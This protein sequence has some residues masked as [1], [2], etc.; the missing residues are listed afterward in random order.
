M[1]SKLLYRSKIEINIGG[2]G[3]SYSDGLSGDEGGRIG[4]YVVQTRAQVQGMTAKGGVVK[5]E[6]AA[7]T[8]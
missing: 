3:R 7:V 6:S 4:R 8:R 2:G 1:W 5:L